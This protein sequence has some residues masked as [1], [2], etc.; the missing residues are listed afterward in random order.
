MAACRCAC[1]RLPSVSP[2]RPRH[3]HKSSRRGCPAACGAWRPA[4][5]EMGSP[6]VAQPPPRPQRHRG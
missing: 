4:G 5:A 6:P 2:V 3:A 1:C